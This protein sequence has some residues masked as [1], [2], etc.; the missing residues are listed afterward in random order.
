[1]LF[2]KTKKE[3]KVVLIGLDGVPYDL[4]K[5]YAQEGTMKNT[6]K[7]LDNSMITRM[8]SSIPDVSSVAWSSFNT[9]HD[10]SHHG[11]FGFMDMDSDY[12]MYFPNF[13]SLKKQTL[14]EKIADYNKKI[15][16]INIP[17]TYPVRPFNGSI[18]SG[19]ISLE[20]KKS[21]HPP[22]L[23]PTIDKFKYK[24]D[25]EIPDEEDYEKKRDIIMDRIFDV[26][27]SRI[28][29]IKHMYKKKEWDLFMGVI[30]ETDRLHHYF[31]DSFESENKY[32]KR[33]R[34]IYTIIDELIG[35]LYNHINTNN[36]FI[37]SDHGFTVTKY[38]V[39]INNILIKE[40]LLKLKRPGGT[41]TDLDPENTK[42]FSLDPARIYLNDERFS[43]GRDYDHKER[44][45][46]IEYMMEIFSSLKFDNDPVFSHI[47]KREDIYSGPLAKK[48]A[49]ILLIP[50]YGFDPKGTLREKEIFV[51]P[52]LNGMHSYDNAFFIS[53]P[54]I[55]IPEGFSVKDP[56]W[57]ILSKIK[58]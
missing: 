28:K 52:K 38:D 15:I 18:V 27:E 5:K 14:W 8:N 36:F 43:K 56:H 10:A 22:S 20:M 58:Q 54:N 25:I 7:I 55:D 6:K 16:I 47:I 2:S 45:R 53:S 51:K 9:G 34:E 21:I 4:I 37:M 29:F 1:M 11:V 46:I 17:H 41:I 44:A 3:N 26:L 50:E 57:V 48:G 23:L 35:N 49:D 40:G 30:T 24:I 33:F 13:L 19:F 39:L 31:F 32:S 12:N 42:A